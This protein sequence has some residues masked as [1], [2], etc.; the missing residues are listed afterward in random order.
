MFKVRRKEYGTIHTVYAVKRIEPKPG[1][2][3]SK[4]KFLVFIGSWAW[5]DA[6]EFVPIDE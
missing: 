5:A 6:D 1:K 4:T 3:F 2:I